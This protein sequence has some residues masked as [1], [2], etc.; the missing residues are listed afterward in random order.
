MSTS[1]PAPLEALVRHFSD[2]RDGN[3]FGEVSRLG[4]EQMFYKA[5]ELLD[6]SARSVLNE[7][8]TYLLLGTGRVDFTDVR[9]DPQGGLIASWMLVWEEQEKAGLP[10]ISLVATYG[11]GFHH[12]HLRGATVREWPLNVNTHQQAQEL[13]PV[14]RTIAGS[15]LHNLV[16]KV[17]GDWRIIPATVQNRVGKL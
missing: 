5:V 15:D 13:I 3:H 11:A 12:P 4:K 6:N 7:F 16:F 8:N 14:L 1:V 10:P 17:G 2:L 9:K